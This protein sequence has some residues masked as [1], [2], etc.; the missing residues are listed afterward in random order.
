MDKIQQKVPN[1]FQIRDL[2][3]YF[4]FH[5][6]AREALQSSPGIWAAL[7]AAAAA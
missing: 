3:L 7:V 2:K 5:A 6:V 1:L 4:R